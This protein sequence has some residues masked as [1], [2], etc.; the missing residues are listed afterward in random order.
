[1]VKYLVVFRVFKRLCLDSLG[2]GL[3]SVSVTG[4]AIS[5]KSFVG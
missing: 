3:A 2:P 1:M 4:W 5:N